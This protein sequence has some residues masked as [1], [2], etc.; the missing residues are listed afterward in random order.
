MKVILQE[1]QYGNNV[2]Q[3]TTKGYGNIVWHEAVGR[4]FESCRVYHKGTYSKV[5]LQIKFQC[6]LDRREIE[7][8]KFIKKREALFHFSVEALITFSRSRFPRL[9]KGVPYFLMHL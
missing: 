4:R 3:T 7:K 1:F 9:K 6:L 5:C 8:R 2:F